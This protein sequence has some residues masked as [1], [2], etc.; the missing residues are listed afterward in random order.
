MGKHLREAKEQYEC[1]MGKRELKHLSRRAEVEDG[2][3]DRM[4]WVL[5]GSVVVSGTGYQV[6]EYQA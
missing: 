6:R 3:E 1:E 5:W 4:R 2:D